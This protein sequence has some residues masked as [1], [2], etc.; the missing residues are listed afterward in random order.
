MRMHDV[1]LRERTHVV[2]R[3]D[4]S[5]RMGTG[6]LM[7]CLSLATELRSQGADVRFITRAHAGHLAK[8]IREQGFEVIL[9][10]PGEISYAPPAQ[11]EQ[12]LGVPWE[13]DAAESAEALKQNAPDWLVVDHYGLDERWERQM[14]LH[15][16][17]VM[18]IDD[19]PRPHSCDLL[20]NQNLPGRTEKNCRTMSRVDTEFL[21]GPRYALLPASFREARQ[22]ARPRVGAIRRLVLFFGG[23][24]STNETAKVLTALESFPR[25]SF[26]VDVVAGALNANV[27][28]LESHCKRLGFRFHFQADMADI[29]A[30]A[31]LAFGAPGTSS[32][33]RMCLG[34]PSLVAAVAENQ[35]SNGAAL[36][37]GGY[38]FYLGS[39][40]DVT[41]EI[42]AHALRGLQCLPGELERQ[43]RRGMELVDGK[44]T[45]RVS[46]AML[47]WWIHFRKAVQ[48]DS[49]L[50][51]KWRNA[52]E[53]RRWSLDPSPISFEDH[54]RWFQ[55]ALKNPDRILLVAQRG[56]EP[57]GVIRFDC[58]HG[59]ATISIYLAPGEI[60]NGLG[61]AM[62]RNAGRWLAKER[63]DVGRIDAEILTAN[64][65]SELTFREAGYEKFSGHYVLNVN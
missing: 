12:W 16:R 54:Q 50:L 25:G 31:D 11:Y 53:V 6:H 36:A 10:P 28:D 51:H 45:R 8:R 9:L 29:Y 56:S 60:G 21:T 23:S 52:E 30:A 13:T 64:F 62:L 49:C 42:Y 39:W 63:P 17:A 4:A 38:A 24:D 5:A 26:E 19:L 57:I 37:E 33:E 14:R 20:L 18:V 27:S 2:V 1:G 47:N 59:R 40:Y 32:W 3:V 55:S 58:D 65:A 44:G 61:L 22:H 43:S 41:A 35:Q 7:R 46:T 15:C 48:D 34:V